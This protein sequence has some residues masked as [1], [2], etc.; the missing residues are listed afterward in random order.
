[1]QAS[2]RWKSVLFLEQ[3]RWMQLLGPFILLWCESSESSARI[4]PENTDHGRRKRHPAD[5][6]RTF[7]ELHVYLPEECLLSR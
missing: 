3:R 7:G 1:M 5:Q 2:G 6:D 4:I